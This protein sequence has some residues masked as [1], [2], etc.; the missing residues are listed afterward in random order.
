[1]TVT[2][3]SLLNYDTATSHGITVQASDAAG[4]TSTASFTVNVTSADPRAILIGGFSLT[5]VQ[6]VGSNVSGTAPLPLAGVQSLT[7][8]VQNGQYN[9]STAPLDNVVIDGYPLGNAVFTLTNSGLTLAGSA[10]LPLLGSVN[11]SGPARGINSY[12]LSVV[13]PLPSI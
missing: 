13:A 12:N 11:L 9:L 2:D 10:D 8:T 3:G 7:G 5:N 6:I 1:V 4:S